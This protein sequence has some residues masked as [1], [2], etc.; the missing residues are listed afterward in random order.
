MSFTVRRMKREGLGLIRSWAAA[1]QWNPGLHDADAFFAADPE[2]FFLGE[3]DG[4][5]AACISCVA[6]GT[7]FGFLGQYIVRPEFR[8]RGY[9]LA[10]WKA[11]MQHLGDRNIG[12]DGVLNQ[13]ENYRTSGFHFAHQHIRYHARGG[14]DSP[15]GLIR[16]A[17][18]PFEELF[19]YDRLHFPAE[20]R[21]FLREWIAMAGSTA[22]GSMR[23]GRLAGYG[24]IRP[25]QDGCKVGPLFAD[26][27]AVARDL[28]RA[29]LATAPGQTVAID[30]PEPSANPHAAEFVETLSLVEVFRTARMYTKAPP[31]LPL[32]RI[33]GV[34]TL[35]LG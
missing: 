6:Y 15:P 24:V 2:G 32:D 18:V 7:G 9:G 21:E 14:G 33:F 35:E 30:V 13:Q 27:P 17:E 10:V 8:G 34:T 23:F 4:E 31:A 12:L 16:L 22:L 29:L 5:P 26:D 3:L 25:S 11:G 20:R 1:E 19:R 28:L